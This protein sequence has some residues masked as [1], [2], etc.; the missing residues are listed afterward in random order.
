MS[1]WVYLRRREWEPFDAVDASA[2]F[3][4]IAIARPRRIGSTEFWEARRPLRPM[5][6]PGRRRVTRPCRSNNACTALIAGHRTSATRPAGA[7]AYGCAPA[8]I[9]QL[10]RTVHAS[11]A[12]G[13]W[14]AWR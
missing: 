12:V 4:V 5:P 9:L 13:S 14:L 10:S 3:S 7:R 8:R 6:P 2:G 1:W 11:I